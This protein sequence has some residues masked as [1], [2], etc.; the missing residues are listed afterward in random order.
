M[1]GKF[2]TTHAAFLG[3]ILA[4]SSFITWSAVSASASLNNLVVLVPV[5]CAIVILCVTIIISGLRQPISV[6][7]EDQST[8][9]GDVILL[10]GFALFCFALSHIGFDVATFLFVWGGVVMSGSKGLWQPPVFAAVFTVFLVKGFGA[11]FPY[12]MLTL[13]L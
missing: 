5:A 3:I 13:V 6:E 10:T 7:T 4:I 11:L 12:P 9:W 1:I 8:V 2:S